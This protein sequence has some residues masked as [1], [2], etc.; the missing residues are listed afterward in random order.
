MGNYIYGPTFLKSI[1][2]S[3]FDNDL[4]YKILKERMGE[5]VF[6]KPKSKKTDLTQQ[7]LASMFIR[8]TRFPFWSLKNNKV[9]TNDGIELYTK[10]MEK[11][12]LSK[13]AEAITTQNLYSWYINL[14]NSFHWQGGTVA[15]LD[16]TANEYGFQM[17]F[18][19]RDSRILKFICEMPESW[20]RGLELKPTKY[21]LKWM[22]ENSIDYPIHLQVGPH[23][24]LYDID[25]S[26]DHAAEWIYHSAFSHQY[27][28]KIKKREYRDILS[29]DVFN[30]KYYDKIVTNYLN[31]EEVKSGLDW[32]SNLANLIFF[33]A[34]GWYQ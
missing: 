34:M 7:I 6:E 22:L 19:F 3:K 20:G 14:Y 4:V 12:Y 23:S 15:S 32:G 30:L 11:D 2:E 13:P 29:K 31:Q 26:F 8:D 33:T 21:P 9:L 24:Y 17:N 27:K 10:E 25:P 16:T 1:W 5:C 28:E 18:P